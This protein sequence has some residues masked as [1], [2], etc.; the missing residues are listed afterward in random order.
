MILSKKTFVKIIDLSLF[1]L[2]LYLHNRGQ[3][4]I[5]PFNS[6]IYSKITIV[7]L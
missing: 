7:L 3:L 4:S 2:F 5:L 6:I 1:R